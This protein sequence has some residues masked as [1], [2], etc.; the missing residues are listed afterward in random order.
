MQAQFLIPM[1]T[2]LGFGVMFSTFTSLLLVPCLYIVLEDVKQLLTKT[3]K[4]TS[5]ELREG[6]K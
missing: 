1:A 3:I 4:L 6:D 2:T 5:L